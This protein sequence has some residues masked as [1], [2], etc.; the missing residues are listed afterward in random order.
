MKNE[1]LL[2]Y[3]FDLKGSTVDRITNEIKRNPATTLKD[4]N[5]MSYCENSNKKGKSFIKLKKRDVFKLEA[6]IRKDV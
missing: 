6:A 4:V 1:N 3:V 5:F 2:K